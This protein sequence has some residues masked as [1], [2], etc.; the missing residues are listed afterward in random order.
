MRTTILALLGLAALSLHGCGKEV[1]ESV[2]ETDEPA[3]PTA[4]GATLSGTLTVYCGRSESLVGPVLEEFR[5][6]HPDLGLG[7][8]YGKTAG[9]AA[10]ILEE[11]DASPCDLY[12]AQDA[13]AL[14]ALSGRGLFAELDEDIRSSAPAWL[15]SAKKD[16]VG[17]SGR[18]RV[19][20]YSTKRMKKEDLPASILDFTK[21]EWKGRIGWPPMNGSY[22]AFVSALRVRIGQEK[23][24]AWLEG[25]MANE[26]KVYPKN[27]PAVQ[28]I[29]DGEIDVAFVNHYYLYRFLAEH[30]ETFPVRN[31]HM[32]AGD[33][34][35]LV[36]VAGAGILKTSKSKDAA[37]ALL[38]FLLAEEAQSYFASKTYEYP[39]LSS[40]K[41]HGDLTPLSE[42]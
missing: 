31:A 8:R 1:S 12:F 23:A 18:A 29:A 37:R 28:A 6:A 25:I 40:V 16:W 42:V 11:G 41:P 27:T 3:A 36:N 21:P 10:Q 20:A 15:Q 7:I 32:S 39:V 2:K 24:K 22:Q 14:G 34:G 38:R 5:Q 19:V 26:P 17:I 33:A 35:N 4:A 9:L 30:G 13:G